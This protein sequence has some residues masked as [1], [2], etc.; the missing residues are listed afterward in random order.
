[1]DQEREI[2]HVD[3]CSWGCSRATGC[4]GKAWRAKAPAFYQ[5]KAEQLVADA[6]RDGLV[7]TMEQRPLRPFAQGHYETVV[8]V[9]AARSPE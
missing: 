3:R 1:M 4:E 2:C 8:S 5:A 7:L 6:A 9:R